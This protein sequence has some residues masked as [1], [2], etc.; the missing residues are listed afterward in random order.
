MAANIFTGAVNNNISVAGNWSLGATPVFNDGNVATFDATSP[1]CTI[2]A[3]FNC[4]GL[5]MT[6]YTNT[7]S[8][9]SGFTIYG[10]LTFGGTIT[11]TSS[12]GIGSS[13]TWTSN[14]I[15]WSGNMT[16]TVGS[17]TITFADAFV[18]NGN[19]THAAGGGAQTFNGSTFTV[20]GNWTQSSGRTMLGTTSVIIGGTAGTS[21]LSLTGTI[22]NA[23]TLNSTNAISLGSWNQ[24]GG[25]FTY[26][27]AT[28]V[29]CT[30]TVS[31][32]ASSTINTNGM[33]FNAVSFSGASQT[34][35]IS[36]DMDIN[37]TT[38]LSG[39]GTTTF[40]GNTIKVGANL[41]INA[42][43]TNTGTT[44]FLIDG[45][46]TWASGATT[47]I[48]A[49]SV[50]INTAGT[51]TLGTIIAYTTG[52]ITYVAGTVVNTG[53]TTTFTGSTTLNTAGMVWNNITISTTSTI[54][55]NSLLTGTGTLTTSSINASFLGTAGFTFAN[56]SMTTGD[57]IL[58]STN[59]Y[60]ITTNITATGTAA[61]NGSFT[62]S[63]GGSQAI[64]TL[65]QGATQDIGFCSATDITSAAGQTIWSYKPTTL[66]NATNWNTLPTQPATLTYSN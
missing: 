63:T 42:A 64:L 54:T 66:S 20:K 19:F 40:T 58:K 36:S 24:F 55:N 23:V 21:T 7:L 10:N 38:T 25:S 47:Q 34:Y 65:N 15:A 4:N 35:T 32:T 31:F 43:G 48:L 17:N 39:T 49:V 22:S 1:N 52:T 30:G 59:T 5:N 62:S 28:S 16:L 50:T 53:N 33:T 14:G 56:Y 8:G 18:L 61:N 51:L 26:T 9:A 60:T 29:T 12:I 6:G 57:N 2:N 41:T 3:T 27:A 13:G 45:T 11:A 46:G 37:G 44:L